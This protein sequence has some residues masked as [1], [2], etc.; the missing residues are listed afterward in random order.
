MCAR[1][2]SLPD[3]GAS[4]AVSATEATL[5]KPPVFVGRR[6]ETQ[7]HKAG[8]GGLANRNEP[9][10]GCAEALEFFKERKVLVCHVGGFCH[11][12]FSALCLV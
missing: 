7:L 12:L 3:F 9:R 1:P 5:Q 2:D 10:T 6:G 4:N 11:V 8:H